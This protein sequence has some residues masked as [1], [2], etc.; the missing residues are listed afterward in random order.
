MVTPRTALD[1]S[2]YSRMVTLNWACNPGT[3]TGGLVD[4]VGNPLWSTTM[5]SARA[6]L[7]AFLAPG[8]LGAGT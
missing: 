3:G 5:P 6:N 2:L 8:G 4:G 1:A 7:K